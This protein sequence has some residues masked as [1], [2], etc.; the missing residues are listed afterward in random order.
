MLII[1]S[2]ICQI[3]VQISILVVIVSTNAN[4]VLEVVMVVVEST[5]L[6]QKDVNVFVNMWVFGRVMEMHMIASIWMIHIA[7]KILVAKKEDVA[8]VTVQVIREQY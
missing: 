2:F 5:V 6:L 4:G 7:S 3:R 1:I 8:K